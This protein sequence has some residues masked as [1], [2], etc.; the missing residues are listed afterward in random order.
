MPLR[1]DRR[2]AAHRLD[3]FATELA[4]QVVHMHFRRV[5]GALDAFAFEESI[6][7][8]SLSDRDPECVSVAIAQGAQCSHRRRVANT[9]DMSLRSEPESSPSASA[10]H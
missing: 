7:L 4:A 2:A 3:R 9:I 10:Q 6:Q 1:R 5:A 8:V